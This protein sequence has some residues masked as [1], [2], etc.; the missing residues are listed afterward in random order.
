MAAKSIQTRTR[1]AT[2][3][4]LDLKPDDALIVVDVQRD[5]LPGGALGVEHGD[6]VIERLNGY[7]DAFAA[8]GLPI[9]LTR[10]WHPADH[11]SFQAAGGR[12]PSHCVQNSPGADWPDGLRIPSTA[13]IIS[14]GAQS[15]AEAYSGFSG[16]SLLALLRELKVKRVF[17]GGLAT[18]YC[19]HATVIDARANAF[20]VVVLTDAVRAV[21]AQP[22]DDERALREMIDHGA[23]LHPQRLAVSG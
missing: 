21:N 3:D 10:D 15:D 9:V 7:M 16:T 19:V 22:G 11:C 20:E 4:S 2:A 13:H 17:V 23:A 14:K 6:Q 5:F 12:W 18:D 1:S 8:C